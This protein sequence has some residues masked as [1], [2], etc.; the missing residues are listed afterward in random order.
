MFVYN[1]LQHIYLLIYYVLVFTYYSHIIH[2][3]VICELRINE[4]PVYQL[5]MNM[6]TSVEMIERFYSHA[7]TTDPRFAA[8]V[9]K[10]NQS[11]SGKALPF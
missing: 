7:R 8:S 1:D 11:N 9:T 5:A 4:V 3:L 6:G 10:G 2:I